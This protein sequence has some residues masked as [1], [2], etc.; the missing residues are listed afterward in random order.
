VLFARRLQG[1]Y[2]AGMP[3]RPDRPPAALVDIETP[4]GRFRAPEGDLITNQLRDFG[5]HTRN[6]L[7][8]LRS[9]VTA[10]DY[11]IDVGGHIGTFAIPLAATVGPAG[12]VF[13]VE[14]HP[15]SHALLVHN[16]A[17]N[18]L[19]E[20]LATLRA[21]VGAAP[22]AAGCAEASPA[23]FLETEGNTGATYLVPGQAGEAAQF[24][25]LDEVGTRLVAWGGNPK[26]DVL[27]IDVEGA[28]LSV[29]RSG[30]G[31]I[32]RFLP[33]VYLEVVAAQ[34]ARF[35]TE[36]A[37][38]EDFLKGR[39]YRFFRNVGPRNSAG[40]DFQVRQLARLSDGG[41]FFDCLAIHAESRRLGP[42]L[43]RVG[44][45]G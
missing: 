28:E 5:A 19:G 12:R 45:A 38:I 30:A 23:R 36:V 16:V 25:T 27:K 37:M 35:G 17:V 10:G 34:L 2:D 20:R 41:A 18:G 21:A 22:R 44:E 13:A 42:V 4:F 14:P 3:A 31:V 15:A 8:F 40:D 7:A 32:G 9:V 29:L 11:V 24:V 33:V 26:L 1:L 43:E 6:E 39:G